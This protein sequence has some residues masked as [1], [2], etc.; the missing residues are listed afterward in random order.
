MAN[1]CPDKEA[2]FSPLKSES[3]RKRWELF[4]R[5]IAH[6]KQSTTTAMQEEEGAAAESEPAGPMLT[7]VR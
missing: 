3:A 1:N 5:A 7:I 6:A 4:H 2:P